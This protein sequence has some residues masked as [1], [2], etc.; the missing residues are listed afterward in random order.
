MAEKIDVILINPSDRKQIYQDLGDE[1]CGI[2]PP[3]FAGLFATYL[4]NKGLSVVIL[5]TPALNMTAGQTAK[6]VTDNFDPVLVVMVVYGYQP[7]AST[8]NMTAAG[9]I[10]RLI[11]ELNPTIKIMM[12]GTHPAALPKQ[13]MKE[14]WIDYVCD[15]EGPE[16]ILGTVL[17]LKSSRRDF[18]KIPNLWWRT[19]E[20]IIRPEKSAPLIKD[21]DNEMSGIAWDLLPMGAYRAH[22]W[23]C[24]DH[25]NERQPYASIHTSLGCPYTCSF[26][27]INAP[28]GKP[29]YRRWSPEVVVGEIDSLVY[30]Y[31]VKNIK[32]VDEMFVLNKRHV[33]GI[34]ELLKRR[35]YD[36]NIWAYARIDTVD[37]SLLEP[38]KA[39]GINWLCLG[40]E[41]ASSTVR[42]GAEKSFDDNDI[43]ATVKRIQDAGIYI[44]G[45]Y[46]F[47]LPD[48]TIQRMQGTLDL[49]LELN[50]EFANFYSAMPYPGSALYKS[51]A[52]MNYELPKSWHQY[53]QHAYDTF[54]LSND[55]CSSADILEFRDT[56][57]MKYFTN[58]NYLDMVRGKF[59]QEVVDHIGRMVNVPFTRKLTEGRT[60]A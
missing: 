1:F 22:N 10:S 3:V 40:I 31:G 12:T 43:K 36:V 54:P 5:D 46:I 34:C 8:Q 6:L 39:A 25:I 13:T 58:K 30:K 49:A 42:D 18:S 28:F 14:E 7:S 50:C 11:K 38:M 51:A 29:A 9:K 35:P 45:N 21:L 48:D 24:F 15:L 60:A 55:H 53:S 26:C 27:C 44:I 52:A 4:R 19:E 16:T 2:E 20:H 47:G 33:L 56:A 57:W 17:V 41:S 23:H 59:G 37:E 32:F